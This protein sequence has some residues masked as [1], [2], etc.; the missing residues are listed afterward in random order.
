MRLLV[1]GGTRFVGRHIVEAGLS[2]GHD[3]T[4]LHRGRTGGNLFPEAEHLIA[5]RDRDLGALSGREWDATVDVCGYIPTQVTHL[6]EALDGRGGHHVFVSS[7]SAYAE[8]TGPGGTEATLELVGPADPTV[9][10]VT[11]GTYGG[12]KVACEQ[13]AAQAYGK[14]LTVVRPTYVIGPWDPTG[15][16][17]WW[18]LRI[19]RG[20]E[21]LAPGPSD[22]PL[23]VIDA[24]DHAA[25]VLGLAERGQGGAFHAV[26]PVPPVGI[27]DVLEAVASA[28]APPGTTLTWVEPQWLLDQGENGR[29]LPLWS[30]GAPEW[31]MALDPSAA[32]ATGLA[33]RPLAE[34]VR[35]TAAWARGRDDV[36]RDECGISPEREADLLSRWR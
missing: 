13:A 20:G 19:A 36:L 16:F 5:D 7:V 34:S 31:L 12:L 17:P 8:A 15:R 10:E 26:S 3:V 30:E 21:V 29:S 11:P 23:Q 27:G 14:S 33:P 9:D 35:D 28:V 18:V 32:Y 6:A 25:W 1:I 22:A 4:L 24:R 2:A